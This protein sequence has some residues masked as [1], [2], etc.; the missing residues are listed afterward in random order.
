MK[1]LLAACL[2]FAFGIGA[3]NAQHKVD[4]IKFYTEEYPPYNFSQNGQLRG[5]FIDIFAEMMKRLKA[6]TTVSDVTMSEWAPAYAK[7]LAG[8]NIGLFCMTK[9]E[10]RTPLFKWVGPITPTTIAVISQKGKQ[11]P[12]LHNMIRD[13]SVR[14]FNASVILYDIGHTKAREIGIPESNIISCTDIADCIKDLESG[15]TQFLIYEENV[16]KWFLK[17]A[18]V[19]DRYETVATLQRSLLSFAFS[20]DVDDELIDQMQEIIDEMKEEGLID[21]IRN[22]YTN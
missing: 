6:R 16:G 10:A 14:G 11:L 3:A 21:Q 8:P 2:I 18:G 1:K 5:I 17:N 13:N 7:A 9:T 15:R 19:G 20:M 4:S 22:R 12:G